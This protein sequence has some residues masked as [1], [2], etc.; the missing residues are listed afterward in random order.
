[1]RSRNDR[2]RARRAEGVHLRQLGLE[3]GLS[4][5]QVARIL[6]ESGGDPLA[7]EDDL[8]R[9]RDRLNDRI[10]ADTRRLAVVEQELEALRI[11]R[12]LGL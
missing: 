12:I 9:E 6:R 1:M 10:A 8:L 5:V 11:D 7:S 3:F 2:L 4:H